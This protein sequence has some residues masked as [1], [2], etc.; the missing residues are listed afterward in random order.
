M[1]YLHL[2][3]V[4]VVLVVVGVLLCWLV[5]ELLEFLHEEMELEQDFVVFLVVGGDEGL[6]GGAGGEKEG[7][8]G[9]DVGGCHAEG[10][11]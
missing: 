6:E 4:E 1:D 11:G 10:R 3:G 7:A 5:E 9:V 8:E 2:Q